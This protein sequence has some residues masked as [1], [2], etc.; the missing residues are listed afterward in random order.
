MAKGEGA[1]DKAAEGRD[2]QRRS[3]RL[4][5]THVEIGH[6][7]SVDAQG[8]HEALAWGTAGEGTLYS[9]NRSRAHCRNGRAG[10][11]F[12]PDHAC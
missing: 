5:P 4:T 9:W 7:V 1:K 12:Q 2:W 10:L 3:A 11:H 8:L 6:V